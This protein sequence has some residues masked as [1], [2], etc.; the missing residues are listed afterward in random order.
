MK[1]A[2]SVSFETTTFNRTFTQCLRFDFGKK[3]YLIQGL[4]VDIANEEILKTISSTRQKLNLDTSVWTEGSVDIVPCPE[5]TEMS[6]IDGL[7][8]TKYRLPERIENVVSAQIIDGNVTVDNY[9]R[10]MHQLL[11]TEEL[12]MKKAISRYLSVD[13]MPITLLLETSTIELL[14]YPTTFHYLVIY[15]FSRA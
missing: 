11:F 8:L 14:I 13:I 12:F 4:N 2:V 10:V 6:A 7:L 3:P 15:R 1:V 5:F 9:K